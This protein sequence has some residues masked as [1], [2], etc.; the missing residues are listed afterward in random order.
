MSTSHPCALT[1]AFDTIHETVRRLQR[2]NNEL[3]M[4][5]NQGTAA[6]ELCVRERDDARWQV[7]QLQGALAR[8]FGTAGEVIA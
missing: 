6:L 4:K 3:R 2:E 5:N 1:Q 7:K 8:K